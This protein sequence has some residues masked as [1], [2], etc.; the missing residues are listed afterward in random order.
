MNQPQPINPLSFS[1]ASLYDSGTNPRVALNNSNVVVEVHK[2]QWQSTIWYHVG[3]LQG[4]FCSFSPSRQY[5]TGVLPSVALN[6]NDVVVEVH[7]SDGPSSN[8]WYHVGLVDKASQVINWG[9]SG[10]YDTGAPPT[11]ALN[12]NGVVVEVHESDGL[13]SKLWYHV[14]IVDPTSKT[15]A[16]SGSMTYD[17][18]ATPCVAINNNGVVVEV[19]QSD[20]PSTNLWYHVGAV[21][22]STKTVNWGPSNQYDSGF[23]PSVTIADNGQV[24]EMHSDSGAALYYR[25]GQVSGSSINWSTNS[26][27]WTSGGNP[28][29]ALRN[30]WAM[31]V[32]QNSDNLM[33]SASQE[34][35]RSTWMKDNLPVLGNKTLG[36]LSLPGSH[37]A[38][39]YMT[40]N[41][42][43]FLGFG[44][45]SCNTQTQTLSIYDQLQSGSRYLDLRPVIDD[46]MLYT[47]HF[48]DSG[49]GCNGPQLSQVF[50]DVKTFMQGSNDLVILQFSHYYDRDA[51]RWSFNEQQYE[52]IC[53]LLRQSVGS[54]LYSNT[55][56]GDLLG[57]DLN[58]FIGRGG[59]VIALFDNLPAAVKK[60]YQD[61]WD[62]RNLPISN[63]YANTNKLSDMI[64]DQKDKLKNSANHNGK[65]FLL[66]W[67][68]TQ[69][70]AQAIACG[71]KVGE[72][73]R[74]LAQ[75]ANQALW[76]TIVTWKN[77]GTITS[78][79]LPNIIYVDDM[80]GAAT[81]VTVWLN[82]QG[83]SAASR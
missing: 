17:S 58:G 2:S 76:P 60:N 27:P 16:W 75:Q 46:K 62:S 30:G 83:L 82:R 71:A 53:K 14:G 36:Q 49:R 1:Y 22:P 3:I 37:D 81:N 23:G 66:S 20:G 45:N 21:N 50:H 5:D 42:S 15:V 33:Y 32:H 43:S 57:I 39:M 24:V 64:E 65:I 77:N 73:I 51:D 69:N 54:Y 52:D 18:G 48:D 13:S 63:D 80:S 72:S 67:T 79:V 12:N 31:E 28:S 7:Q 19:H 6:D 78:Q 9:P 11:V 38:G 55:S 68:L 4:G 34:I 44:A 59:K 61:V 56:A 35:N 29:V 74:D 10:K 25:V 40:Q 47:G 26:I 70:K 41:C 8:L